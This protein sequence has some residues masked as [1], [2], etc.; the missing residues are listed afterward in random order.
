MYLGRLGARRQIRHRL[1]TSGVRDR[2]KG[3]CDEE[4]SAV[5]DGDTVDDYFATVDPAGDAGGARCIRA[6]ED[7]GVYLIRLRP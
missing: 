6:I 4:V 7:T 2:L 5:P 1:R 3:L